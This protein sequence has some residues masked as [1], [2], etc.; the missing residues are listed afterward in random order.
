M[1]IPDPDSDPD[2]AGAIVEQVFEARFQAVS[3]ER[4]QEITAAFAAL[5]T[6]AEREAHE[7]DLAKEFMVDWRNVEG[8]DGKEAP[9][10]QDSFLKALGYPWFRTAVY[11]AYTQAMSGEARAKN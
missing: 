10:S 6:Q 7:F 8:A 3:R 11:E 4:A 1:R 2:K 5:E 9:F